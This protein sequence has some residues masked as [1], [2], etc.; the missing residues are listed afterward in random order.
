MHDA[1]W[2]LKKSIYKE[3]RK[4]SSTFSEVAKKIEEVD[5]SGKLQ[6]WYNLYPDLKD[7]GEIKFVACGLMMDIFELKKEN[8]TI[9]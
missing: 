2:A 8:L 6:V 5:Q 4:V 1:V 3:N 7:I 9:V